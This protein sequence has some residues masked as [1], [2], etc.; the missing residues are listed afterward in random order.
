LGDPFVSSSSSLKHVNEACSAA[1]IKTMALWINEHVIGITAGLEL[2]DHLAVVGTEGNDSGRLA[3][4]H[5]NAGF[6]LIKRHSKVFLASANR[7]RADL[8]AGGTIYDPDLAGIRHV[9]I[10]LAVGI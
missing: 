2:S 10:D 8:L 1:H 9:H 7:P 3:E 5:E 4:Y 6:P